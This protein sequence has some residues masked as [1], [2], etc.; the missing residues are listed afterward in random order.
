MLHTGI[1]YYSWTGCGVCGS[2]FEALLRTSIGP[3]TFAENQDLTP[4]FFYFSMIFWK[5][6]DPALHNPLALASPQPVISSFHGI[7][8]PAGNAVNQVS[9]RQEMVLE[10]KGRRDPEVWSS[11]DIPYLNWVW[12]RFHPVISSQELGE[13]KQ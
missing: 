10:C 5:E 11:R 13:E 7:A 9:L 1:S 6:I 3:L 8:C 2:H 12:L 4:H